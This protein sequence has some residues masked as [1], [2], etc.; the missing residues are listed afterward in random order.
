MY[1]FNKTPSILPLNVK[2]LRHLLAPTPSTFP[3]VYF[4]TFHCIFLHLAPNAFAF[5]TKSS[6]INVFGVGRGAEMKL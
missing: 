2:E 3:V 6:I 4:Y 5:L 1:K